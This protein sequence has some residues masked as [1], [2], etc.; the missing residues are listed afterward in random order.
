MP[1]TRRDIHYW[2]CD[3]PAAFHGTAQGN[4]LTF[5]ATVAA[6]EV[7]VRIE[8]GP[9][10]DDDIAVESFVMDRVRALISWGR[11]AT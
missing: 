4:H 5:I 1:S 9:K 11:K 7:F 10:H 8:D 6:H 3:R 2:K